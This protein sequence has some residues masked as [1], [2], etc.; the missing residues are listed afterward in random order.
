MVIIPYF[1]VHSILMACFQYSQCHISYFSRHKW[2]ISSLALHKT[3]LLCFVYLFVVVQFV[4][5]FVGFVGCW[6]VFF[7]CDWKQSIFTMEEEP[8]LRRHV[9]SA[10]SCNS[11]QSPV[12]LVFHLSLWEN[13]KSLP[14]IHF[15][16]APSLPTQ[17]PLHG[18]QTLVEFRGKYIFFLSQYFFFLH[19]VV[20][21]TCITKTISGVFT[22]CISD[23]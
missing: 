7:Q 1:S 5:I 6:V 15:S 2:N 4:F 9:C 14:W 18:I 12:Q 10:S 11:V 23:S 13:T 8:R 22:F 21:A 20:I 3:V 16:C 17:T 19:G